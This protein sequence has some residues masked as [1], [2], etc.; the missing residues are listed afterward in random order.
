[1]GIL[2]IEMELVGL[3]L[4]VIYVGKKVFGIFIVSD[5]ILCDEV[6]IFEEC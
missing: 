3:Y 4:N 1:M 6:I 5:H 2:G